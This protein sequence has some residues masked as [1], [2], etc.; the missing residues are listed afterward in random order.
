MKRSPAESATATEVTWNSVR[1]IKSSD[2]LA[3]IPQELSSNTEVIQHTPQFCAGVKKILK[4]R[5]FERSEI[6]LSDLHDAMRKYIADPTYGEISG[7]SDDALPGSG[8]HTMSQ[9]FGKGK[10]GA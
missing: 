4:K 10:T 2:I 1:S 5:G 7:A 6:Q 3:N 8:G 9:R